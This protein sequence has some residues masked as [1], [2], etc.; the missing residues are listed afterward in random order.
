MDSETTSERF[1]R[2]G[3]CKVSRKWVPRDEMV[4]ATF[5]IYGSNGKEERVPVRLSVDGMEKLRTM[6]KDYEW[7]NDLR[8]AE[9]LEAEHP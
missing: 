8:T 1:R 9:E 6:M 2:Y 3:Y 4:G 5:K 7:D